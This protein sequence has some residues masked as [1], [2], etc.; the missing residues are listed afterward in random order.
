M[1]RKFNVLA[2]A[3]VLLGTPIASHAGEGRLSYA[4]SACDF[5]QAEAGTCP[6]CKTTLSR[7]KLCY[8]CPTC[9]VAQ[10]DP[11]TCSMCGAELREKLRRQ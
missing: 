1:L 7:Q 6:Q 8:E 9:G 2:M 11:G 3:L 5:H 4:C 10:N